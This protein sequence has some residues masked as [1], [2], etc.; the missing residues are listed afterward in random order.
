MN[1]L[2]TMIEIGSLNYGRCHLSSKH[3]SI[4][5]LRKQLLFHITT[6]SVIV[7][8]CQSKSYCVR[9]IKVA[10]DYAMF[11]CHKTTISQESN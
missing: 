2:K 1:L 9:D 3:E 11:G 7:C 6:K 10:C 5:N 8:N 4:S